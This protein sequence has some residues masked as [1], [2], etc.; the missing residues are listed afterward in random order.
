MKY[1]DIKYTIIGLLIM[2]L[3]LISGTVSAQTP[4][5]AED[6]NTE[7]ISNE[8]VSDTAA[9]VAAEEVPQEE[10]VPAEGKIPGL[11]DFLLSG[12]YISFLIMM[13]AGLV[14]LF[15]KKINIWV[16]VAMMLIA[17][18]LFG[19]DYFFPLHPS[20]MCG[21]TKLPMFKIVYGK[22]F[23]AF[24]AIFLAIFIPS[25]IGRKLFCGW[26]CPLGALQELANKIPH[27]FHFK[28]F[29][30]TAFNTVRFALF[31]LF[32]LTFFYVKDMMTGLAENPEVY[33]NEPILKAYSAYSVYEPVNFFELLHWNIDATFIV[34]MLALLIVSLFLYRPFCYFICPVGLLTWLCEKIAPGRIRV[35]HS[36]C[37]DCGDCE[38]K[39]PCPTIG[40]LKEENARNIPDC[41]SCGE[42]VRACPEDAIRFGFK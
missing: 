16:R 31:G 6:K 3:L 24:L 9:A 13:V 36:K 11:S 14:L 40:K 42:C 39:S 8:T 22:F 17:F 33:I 19:L 20:P 41:T 27:K 15:A 7:Q 35:D 38:E 30:F 10:S 5:A 12:K 32:I 18:V 37:T 26:V 2:T 1:P 28:K 34:M 25:L 29:N 4:A 21:V 23:P